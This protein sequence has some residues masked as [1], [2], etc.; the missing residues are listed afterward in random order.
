[1]NTITAV[2]LV[3]CTTI[4]AVAICICSFDENDMYEKIGYPSDYTMSP[5]R[6]DK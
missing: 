4:I 5:A 2:T 3:L 6:R 1:M